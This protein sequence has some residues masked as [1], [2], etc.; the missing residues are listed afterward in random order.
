[1]ARASKQNVAL[2]W[3]APLL[4]FMIMGW[5]G[6]ASVVQ[7]KRDLRVRVARLRFTQL[8]RGLHA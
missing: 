6:L 5:Y 4:A 1:M 2:V 8:M 3:G 7:T